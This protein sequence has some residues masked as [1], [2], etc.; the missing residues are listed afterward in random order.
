MLSAR[1]TAKNSAENRIGLS[2]G[3]SCATPI[4]YVVAAVRGMASIGP[5]QR[6]I[7]VIRIVAGFLPRRSITRLALPSF[8][9]AKSAT[10]ASAT[11]AM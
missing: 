9:R 2:P 1:I 6:M 5:M 7:T 11:S 10:S 3:I 4:S 8:S